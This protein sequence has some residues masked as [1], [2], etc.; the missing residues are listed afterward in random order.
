MVKWTRWLA[1][2]PVA[3]WAWGLAL[4]VTPSLAG[5]AVLQATWRPDEASAPV[6]V[7]HPV[8]SRLKP[9][10]RDIT[11]L[12]PLSQAPFPYDGVVPGSGKP[13][14][15]VLTQ[16]RLGHRS[17]SGRIF[18]DD[19]TYSDPRVLMHV[20]RGFD[21]RRPGVIVLFFHGHGATLERD[22]I[23]RQRVAEQVTESGAN[24][25][26]I[27]PQLAFD[28]PDSSPGKL[29]EVGGCSRLMAES[30]AQIAALLG[31]RRA[32]RSLASM[33]IV[34]IGY[35]GGFMPVAWCL[36]NGQ[37]DQRIRGVAL[38]DGLYG[39][40][41]TFTHWLTSHRS[42]F[43]VSSFTGSTRS[44]NMELQEVL[45]ER[46]IATGRE[47]APR[48]PPGSVSFLPAADRT[49]RDFVTN[50]WVADPIADLLRRLVAFT[51]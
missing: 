27:A 7:P 40:M 31:D 1:L 47:L 44:Q 29:W 36:H 10:T 41:G 42:T 3:L 9:V 16:G 18:W 30:Q 25:V 26:L 33:P 15:D 38:L 49:H 21:I 50:A 48:L 22:V 34:I 12:V 5:S 20:P 45:E 24:A 17:S 28:A 8:H 32:E 2:A 37:L 14:F 11:R 23:G 6:P 51:G 4:D 19:E 46:A 39:E 35:S 13:F 43:F